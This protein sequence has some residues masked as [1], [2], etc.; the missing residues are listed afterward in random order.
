MEKIRWG[1][2]STG[3]IVD[4]FAESL[5]VLPDHEMVAV[6]SRTQASADRFGDLWNI[7][8]RYDSYQAVAN[9]PDVDVVYIGTPHNLHYENTMMC[10]EA[11]KPVLVE[12]PFAVNAQQA[13]EMI[14]LARSKNLFLMEAM[15]TRF[16]PVM[17]L[18]REWL[19]AGEIG[20]VRL[21]R[22]SLSF[23][24]PFDPAHRLF[25]PELAGGALLDVG[26][27]PISF[28]YMVLGSPDSVA[29]T[30]TL[31]ATNVDEHSTYFFKYASGAAAQLQSGTRVNVP[32]VAEVIGTKGYIR[33]HE[34]FINPR[35]VTLAKTSAPDVYKELIY[36][37][38]LYDTQMIHVPT[39]GN[40]YN[41]EAAEVGRCLRAG[42][43]ESPIMSLDESLDIMQTMDT[44]R[45][46]WGLKYPG[47]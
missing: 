16:Q 9:D 24:A 17:V 37:G 4:K 32:V 44:I 20:D 42:E 36:T 7:P 38:N 10:L 43:T 21:V 31:C 14:D 25:A 2:I 47:E 28:A 1:A 40:G 18:V 22:A 13:R 27:Y 30:A 19:E 46:E 34:P 45:A 26:I 5:Q 3:W 41:Y 6:G 35:V 11:G 39:A 33:V 23:E 12:K 29:S 8:N 15:W